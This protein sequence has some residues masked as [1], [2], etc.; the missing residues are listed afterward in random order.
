MGAPTPTAAPFQE[1]V[2]SVMG[3]VNSGAPPTLL[4][5]NQLA[6][7]VNIAG[8]M[9][10]GLAEY[11]SM[12]LGFQYLVMV[13]ILFYLLSAVGLRTALHKKSEIPPTVVGG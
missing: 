12:L 9:V 8:A 7:G 2:T 6:F 10:G 11:S 1:P 3:G 5:P 4:P 13:A